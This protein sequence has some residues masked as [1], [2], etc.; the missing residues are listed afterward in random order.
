MR[1]SISNWATT[2]DDIDRSVTAILTAHRDGTPSR[3][4]R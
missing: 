4:G 3:P 2:V 1:I